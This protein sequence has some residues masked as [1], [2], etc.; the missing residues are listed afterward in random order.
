MTA[1]FGLVLSGGVRGLHDG[2]VAATERHLR[3]W[4]ITD[5]SPLPRLGWRLDDG[6]AWLLAD[7][8]PVEGALDVVRRL[9]GDQVT[10]VQ[11][12][13]KPVDPLERFGTVEEHREPD[14]NRLGFRVFTVTRG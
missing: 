14:L 12:Q 7:V 11:R 5:Y 8:N 4:T 1:V 2:Q 10:V 13:E 9:D 3:A 6:T